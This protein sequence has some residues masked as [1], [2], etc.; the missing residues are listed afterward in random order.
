MVTCAN[1]LVVG[2]WRR[3]SHVKGHARGEALWG[4]GWFC[5][6]GLVR[7]R[8][9][10]VRPWVTVD[11]GVYVHASKQ[12]GQRTT[13]SVGHE[14]R[15]TSPWWQ[16]GAVIYWLGAWAG[17]AGSE[18]GSRTTILITSHTS[19]VLAILRRRWKCLPRSARQCPCA[20]TDPEHSLKRGAVPRP[21]GEGN[22]ASGVGDTFRC[23]EAFWAL[24][25]RHEV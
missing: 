18:L 19:C 23:V 15:P 9:S 7:L 4:V 14:T 20:L 13:N 3:A 12:A 10:P 21:V 24:R 1:V 8:R 16:K 2:S 25:E 22:R 17:Q 5:P 6:G 11:L